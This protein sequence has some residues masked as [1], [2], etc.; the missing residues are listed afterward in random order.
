M[1]FIGTGLRE[2]GLK[3]RRQRTRMALR[4]V[5]RQLKRSEISLGREGTTQAS[6]LEEVRTEIVALKKLEQEQKEVAVRIAQAEGALKQID[7][8][9]RENS[10][11]QNEEIARLDQ[12]KKPILQRRD[13]AKA[14][15]NLCDRELSSV[16]GRL[17]ANDATDRALMK[18][19]AE[20]QSLSP[21]PDDLDAQME[22]LSSKR[23]RL[24]DERA[25]IIRA[26]EGSAEA[27]RRARQQLAAIEEGIAAADQQISR[28]RGKYE[29]K[30]RILNEKARAQNDVLKEARQH[31]ETVEGRKDP[32]YLN[33]GRHLANRGIAPPNAPRL[34]HDV[35]RNR[36]AVDRH[37][38]HKDELRSLSDQIDKQQL[39]KFYFAAASVIIL[40]VFTLLVFLKSPPH[41][42]WLPQETDAILSLNTDRLEKDEL[43]KRWRTE[44]FWRP[45]WAALLGPAAQAPNLKI[46]G[47]A[48]RLIRAIA[49][50]DASTAPRE[51]AL[52]ET[53]GNATSY[54]RNLENPSFEKRNIS[55]LPVWQ[56]ENFSLARIGPRTLAIGGPAEVDQ[57][58]RVRLG[59]SNDLQPE[60]QLLEH[61][62][63]LEAD[64]SLRLVS[65]DPIGLTRVFQPIFPRELLSRIELIGLSLSL[66]NP[67]KCHLTMTADSAEAA[68]AL[69]K[70]LQEQPQQLLYLDGTELSLF[71]RPPEVKRDGANLEVRFDLPENAARILLQRL[72]KTDNGTPPA[73]TTAAAKR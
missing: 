13:E 43:I 32:A 6:S 31:H 29:D 5:K 65:R 34:L 63:D 50:A 36:Q 7:A 3:V 62:H 55:G 12:K 72:A 47:D 51:F 57:M 17:Q 66:Q 35:L 70:T 24:P 15:A 38:A 1:N 41:S 73:A 23:A 4:H 14:Q 45:T 64:S 68:T 59:L 22:K 2:L 53:N 33:I 69:A 60:A 54:M 11:A 58:V 8:E 9:R 18:K 44:D 26:R 52:I 37:V 40:T 42:D 25:E 67:A 61:L 27:C 71:A 56:R 19:V 48:A 28:V 39:R 10:Q 20:L 46:P 30:D 21:P 49:T 16:E